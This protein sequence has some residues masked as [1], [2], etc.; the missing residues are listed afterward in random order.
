METIKYLFSANQN[1]YEGVRPV[2]IYLMRVLFMLMFFVLGQD[3]WGTIF[4]HTGSWEPNDAMAWCVWAAFSSMALIGIFRTV[5][6]IPL[7]L[8]EIFYKLLWLALV[9][10][11]LWQTDTLAGSQAQGMVYAFLWVL[12][13]IL[14]VPWDYVVQVYILGRKTA[15]LTTKAS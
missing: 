1:K 13:P 7:L 12:L 2:N 5:Q 11:P 14:A 10:L 3:V 15:R 4:S 6:M 8:L 9:A